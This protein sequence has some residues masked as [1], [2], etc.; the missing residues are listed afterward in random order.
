MFVSFGCEKVELRR[1]DANSLKE[2]A[3]AAQLKSNSDSQSQ[4][5]SKTKLDHETW[6]VDF[7]CRV[8][9]K[10]VS[11]KGKPEDLAKF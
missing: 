3:C 8:K 1:K 10:K 2:F 6:N 5:H 4:S 9:G 11:Q 7:A